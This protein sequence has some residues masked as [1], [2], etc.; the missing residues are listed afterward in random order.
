MYERFESLIGSSNFSKIRDINVMIIGL[1]GVGGYAAESLARCGVRSLILV[2]YDTVDISNF[3]RQLIATKENLGK[4][5]VEAF[6]ERISSFSDTLVIP[7]QE[8]YDPILFDTYKPD[9]VI[10]ACDDIQAKQSMIKHCKVRQIPFITS[11]GTGKRLDPSKLMITTLDKTSYDPIARI[12]RKF[13]KDE[14]IRGKITVLASSEEPI[15]TNG[16]EI[17]SCSFVPGVAGM[18]I[19]SW[20]IQSEIKKEPEKS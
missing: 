2:D 3:N 9:Y 1:G 16:K 17:P 11:M 5:K 12:L 18:L 15:R 8:K 20:V 7:I 4:S 19:A 14:W 10:D 13:V 6:K